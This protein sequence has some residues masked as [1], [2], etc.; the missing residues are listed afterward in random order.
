MTEGNRFKRYIGV[1]DEPLC[2]DGINELKTIV[3]PECDKLISSPMKRCIQTAEIIY[4]DMNAEICIG[5]R[6]CDFGIFEGKNYSELADVPE[7]QKWIDSDGKDSFPGGENPAE[8]RE[9]CCSAFEETVQRLSDCGTVSLTVHGGV[10]MAVLEKYAVPHREFYDWYAGNGHGYITESD[11]E[12]I[13]ILE[14][15]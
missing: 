11:G 15:I 3:Y 13:K 14:K 2:S 5:F 7:Y 9:R 6:E 1:T 8:F 10:I 4:P 12:K